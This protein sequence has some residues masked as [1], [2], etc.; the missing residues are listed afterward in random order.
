MHQIDV[1]HIEDIHLGVMSRKQR[2]HLQGSTKL[3][4]CMCGS[5]DYTLCT[6]L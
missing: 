1:H 4:E 5:P 2:N 6:A 3:L